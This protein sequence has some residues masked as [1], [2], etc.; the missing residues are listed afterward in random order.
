M[1]IQFIAVACFTLLATN[2]GAEKQRAWEIGKVL[3]TERNRYFA[4]TYTRGSSSGSFDG[5]GTTIGNNTDV[6][7]TYR[8]Q[9]QS[10]TRAVYRIYAEYVIES[11]KFVY[12][13]EE[14]LLWRWSKPAPLVVNG[15]VKF[16]VEK[17]TLYLRDEEG[18][19]HE[20]KIVKQI[21]KP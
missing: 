11:D 6:S 15:P 13:T 12:L 14:R 7:G 10:S 3:D 9:S 4:G 20:A 21:L 5:S 17:R 18:K 8:G 2:L 16:A 1:R 19:E